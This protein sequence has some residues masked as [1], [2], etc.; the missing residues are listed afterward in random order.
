MD[1]MI[2]GPSSWKFLHF[3]TFGFP[4]NPTENQRAQYSLFLDHLQYVLPCPT[5][6]AHYQEFVANTPPDCTSKQS[7]VVWLWSL[8]NTVNTKNYKP[9][10]TY[11][12]FIDHY[13]HIIGGKNPLDTPF[14]PE[15]S[16]FC[17]RNVYP[18]ALILGT[19]V[20]IIVLTRYKGRAGYSAFG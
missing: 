14:A 16:N 6:R 9:T 17:A 3:V 11:P 1:P 4:T 8:H 20:I 7:L 12:D 5:C 13:S 18:I 10:I 2:W 15:E 19:A